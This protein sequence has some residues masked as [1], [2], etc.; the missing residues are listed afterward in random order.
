MTRALLTLVGGAIAAGVPVY[1]HH[2]FSAS[3]FEN[4]TVRIEGEM[5]EF[6]YRNPHATMMV[7]V[8]DETGQVQTFTAEWGG[9]A[10]LRREGVTAQTFRVGDYL[11]LSGSPGKRPEEHMLHLKRIERP[12]DGGKWGQTRGQAEQP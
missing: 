11:I 12:A 7:A 8:R 2:S 9:T 4:Q 5:V 6:Q 3:Y 10:R 1:A